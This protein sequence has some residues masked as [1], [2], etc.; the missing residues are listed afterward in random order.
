MQK[1][2]F[3]ITILHFFLPISAYIS[4]ANHTSI[5]SRFNVH[6]MLQINQSNFLISNPAFVRVYREP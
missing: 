3:V 1:T 2:P 6:E 5:T 4:E